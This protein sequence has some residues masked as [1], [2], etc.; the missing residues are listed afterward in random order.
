MSE[1]HQSFWANT[2]TLMERQNK[3]TML[4]TVFLK[5]RQRVDVLERGTGEKCRC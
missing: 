2:L 5:A 4:N 3:V 1:F